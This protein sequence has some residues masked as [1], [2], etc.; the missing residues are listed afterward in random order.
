[1]RIITFVSRFAGHKTP[2]LEAHFYDEFVKLAKNIEKLIVVAP[3]YNSEKID[4]PN[5]EVHLAN[6]VDVRKVRGITKILLYTFAAIRHFRKYDL[7][8]LRTLS[9]PDIIA[10]LVASRLGKPLVYR[11]VGT[12]IFESPTVKNRIYAWFFRRM[13]YSSDLILLYSKRMITD[14]KKYAPRLDERKVRIIP[15]SI[16]PSRFR[17]GLNY[18]HLKKEFQV[19]DERIILYAGRI[20][21]KKGIE[22]VIRS[23]KLVLHQVPKVKLL[24]IGDEAHI[25]EIEEMK[26][27]VK[28]L[29]VEN[30]VIFVGPRPNEEIPFFIN[31]ADICICA[32]H[33]G[34]GQTRFLLES[35]AC[36]KPVISTPVAGNPDFVIDGE[37]GFLVPIGDYEKLAEHIVGLLTDD[38]LRRKIGKIG[39]VLILEKF[40]WENTIPKLVASLKLLAS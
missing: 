3:R 10:S 25:K 31:M 15:N 6:V 28:R 16:D 32:S 1:L 35:L 27:L 24:L 9:P 2:S 26:K 37:T 39:R 8:Y 30:K 23:I 13:I 34:E 29:G 36:E 22:D 33:G 21:R 14:L 17:P 5:I 7:I 20:T 18:E 12:W 4:L 38:S 11:A 40:N 19:S